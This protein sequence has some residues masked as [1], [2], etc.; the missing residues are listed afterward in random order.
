[1]ADFHVLILRLGLVWSGLVTSH[2]QCCRVKRFS[3]SSLLLESDQVKSIPSGGRARHSLILITLTNFQARTISIRVPLL[4]I[5]LK[6]FSRC[7]RTTQRIPRTLLV[8]IPSLSFHE[9]APAPLF[10]E[11]PKKKFDRF[12]NG[13]NVSSKRCSSSK[14]LS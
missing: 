13:D 9:C 4:V 10:M 6:L 2:R 14:I 5:G 3:S 8:R 1:M 11:H 12:L 7:A